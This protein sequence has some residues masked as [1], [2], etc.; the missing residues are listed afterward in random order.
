MTNA[1]ILTLSC[2]DRP[3]IVA[4]V[5][6][7][8]AEAGGNIREAQQFEDVE[9]GLFFMRVV[10]DLEPALLEGLE[11][12]FARTAERMAI[13]WRLRAAGARKRVLLMASKWDHCLAD[14][15]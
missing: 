12:S 14:L 11:R 7:E 4:A 5:A 15:L 1:Y 3:G 9:D 8:L 6:S 2:P 13:E 10:F